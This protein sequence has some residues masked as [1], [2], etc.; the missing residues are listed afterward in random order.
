MARQLFLLLG[1]RLLGSPSCPWR[2]SPST[3]MSGLRLYPEASRSCH[4]PRHAVHLR[5]GP[6][7]GHSSWP[8]CAS[9]THGLVSPVPR[10]LS[11]FPL[12]GWNILV[13]HPHPVTSHIQNVTHRLL[14]CHWQP[15]FTCPNVAGGLPGRVLCILPHSRLLFGE[16]ELNSQR[17]PKPPAPW[18][19]LP[20]WHVPTGL[21][22]DLASAHSN[23]PSPPPRLSSRPM[24]PVCINDTSRPRFQLR[25]LNPPGPPASQAQR[26]SVLLLELLPCLSLLP[27][28]L[29]SS[30]MTWLLPSPSCSPAPRCLPACSHFPPNLHPCL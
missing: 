23:P 26:L 24:S 5:P 17:I 18:R 4:S 29:G 1:T 11:I 6:R 20:T 12:H 25:E 28:P 2:P 3:R 13:G 19:R 30:Q 14:T 16:M 7:G 15:P 8:V 10:E 22:R 9:Q 21:P 27:P